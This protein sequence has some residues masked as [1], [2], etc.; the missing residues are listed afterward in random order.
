MME[1]PFLTEVDDEEI[2]QDAL[3]LADGEDLTEEDLQGVEGL[4]FI[5]FPQ[6][7]PRLAVLKRRFLQTSILR[8]RMREAL[9][10]AANR[11]ANLA[12]KKVLGGDTVI[13]YQGLIPSN[14]SDLKYFA[15]LKP[16]HNL[17][18]GGIQHDK[19]LI[20]TGIAAFIDPPTVDKE[21][22]WTSIVKPMMDAEV[23]LRVSRDD[24]ERIQK[25]PM[26]MLA[27]N[28]ASVVH[29]LD[30]STGPATAFHLAFNNARFGQ[31]GF[32]PLKIYVPPRKSI[33]ADVNF[34]QSFSGNSTFR[35]FLVLQ[36]REVA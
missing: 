26:S 15:E 22:D 17:N 18:K 30:G 27:G 36:A 35:L 16:V 19:A 9:K 31:G 2:L 1:Y 10:R 13:F 29:E 8:G 14:S 23:A 24:G 25:F 4:E 3:N 6:I 5:R 32:F 20:I 12:V 28:I 21:T 34:H 7:R 11:G 33:V